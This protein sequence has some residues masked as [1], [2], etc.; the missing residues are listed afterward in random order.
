[1]IVKLVTKLLQSRSGKRL[2]NIAVLFVVK[3]Q[4]T[5]QRVIN[6]DDLKIKSNGGYMKRFAKKTGRYFS[7]MSIGLFATMLGVVMAVWCFFLDYYWF[8]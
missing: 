2:R 7:D 1:M 4:L 6:P 8:V 3:L 5:Y